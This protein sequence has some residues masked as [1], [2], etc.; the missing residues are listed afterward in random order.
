MNITS[1]PYHFE[2][3]GGSL[4][5]AVNEYSRLSEDGILLARFAAP[6]KNDTA[7]DLGSGN[8]IIPL[9][10]C[11]RNPPAHITAVER[12][13]AFVELCRA[14][15]ERSGVA[16]RVTVVHA[17]WNDREALPP[18]GSMTL[19]T[20]NPPYFPFGAS[21]PSPDA[22][23]QAA[24]TE[25]NPAVLDEVCRAAKRLLTE[26]GRFCLCHR[27]ERLDDVLAAMR[28]AALNPRRLQ[29]VQSRD[30]A[31]PWLFLLETAASGSL[32]VLPPLIPQ[33]RGDHTAVYKT[34]YR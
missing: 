8:G 13:A 24:R 23:R 26:S 15:V 4:A 21:R 34:L 18:A 3:I 5:V 10:W 27:P 16:D 28:R 7:C 25:D 32:N 19:V 9:Y 29:F 1:A 33:T 11:R 2:S 6:E 12:E 20:C 22:L 30:N 14:S 31:A 17:D